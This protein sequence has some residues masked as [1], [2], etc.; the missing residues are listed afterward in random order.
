[1]QLEHAISTAPVLLLGLSHMRC[2]LAAQMTLHRHKVCVEERMWEDPEEP[3]YRYMQCLYPDELEGT[4]TAPV[5]VQASMC[6]QRGLG[7]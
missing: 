5:L 1:M 7:A 4:D 6:K 2:T 3:Q